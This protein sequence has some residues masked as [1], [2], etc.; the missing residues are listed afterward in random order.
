M[1]EMPEM[2][3]LLHTRALGHVAAR[4]LGGSRPQRAGVAASRLG[5]AGNRFAAAAHQG[6]AGRMGDPGRRVFGNRAIANVALQSQFP[7]ARFQGGFS[8]SAWPWW[9]GGVVLGWVGPLF[10][11]YAYYDLFDYVY[12]P[13]AHDD[14]WPYAYDDVYYGIYAEVQHPARLISV[15]TLDLRRRGCGCGC[16]GVPAPKAVG[17]AAELSG[18]GTFLGVRTLSRGRPKAA[19]AR[20]RSARGKGLRE[21][22]GCSAALIQARWNSITSDSRSAAMTLNCSVSAGC[23]V[24]VPEPQPLAGI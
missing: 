15:P 12:W 3:E 24:K 7:Q 18:N 22:N 14:F 2:C 17:A 6:A 20:D 23:P 10:W 13:Y 8:G 11:P 16:D 9:R 19:A 21:S 5:G 4:S 1:A